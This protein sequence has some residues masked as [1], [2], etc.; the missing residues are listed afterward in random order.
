M[1]YP[2]KR[3]VRDIPSS[4]SVKLL[5][6][7]AKTLDERLT[8]KQKAIVIFLSEHDG[9]TLYRTVSELSEELECSRSALY[10]NINSLKRC[11]LVANSHRRPLRLSETAKLVLNSKKESWR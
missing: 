4:I 8:T 7:F 9:K 6:T 2:G 11:G 5:E 3:E 1:E 10:N